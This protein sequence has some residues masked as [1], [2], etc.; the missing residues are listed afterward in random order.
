MD[1]KLQRLLKIGFTLAGQ[2]KLD[3]EGIACELNLHAGAS[4]VLYAFAVDD[5]LAYVGK[6]VQPLRVRMNGYRNP[7]ATQSTNVR[8]NKNIRDALAQGKKVD[9]YV[10][11]DNGLLHYGGFHVNLTAGLED[12]VIRLLAPPWNGGQKESANQTP[13]PVVS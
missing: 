8:N 10:L 11:P 4:N 13:E 7:G 1:D 12:D 9:V 3:G 6:T 2:W 5:A